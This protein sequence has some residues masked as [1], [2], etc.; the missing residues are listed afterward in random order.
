MDDLRGIDINLIVALDAILTERNLTRAGETIG[1]AQPAMSGAVAKLR[2]L[3][4]DPLLVRSGRT[5]ELT[6]RALELQPIARQAVAQVT[7]TLNI[8]PEFDPRT[9]QRQFRLVAS[10]YALSVMT[11]PLLAVLREEAP[12]V[13]VDFRP[14]IHFGPVDLLRED[15]TVASAS[16]SLPG[17]RR[18]L[19]SDSTVCIVRRGHPRLRDGALTLDDLAAMPYVQVAIGDGV[20]MYA[21][22]ALA[23]AGIVPRVAML[24]PGLLAAPYAVAGTDMY[25]FVPARLAEKFADALDLQV[26]RV[27][28]PMPVL[29]ESAFWHPSRS[30]DPA[31]M[32]LLGILL[33]VA[34]RV[35]F[36][37][38]DSVG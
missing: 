10:D 11:A 38:E 13:S 1:L 28:V 16:R 18:A 24:V 6:P 21:D 35:E 33:T 7:R 14:L 26:A 20:V 5:S 31:L 8:R 27:P 3:I 29:V 22:G 34:E 19:F 32:W 30:D 4:G 2:V 9:S 12:N 17:K 37:A 23:E 36:S 15:V 25:S